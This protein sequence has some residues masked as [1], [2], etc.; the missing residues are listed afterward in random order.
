[1]HRGDYNRLPGRILGRCA[2]GSGV[3]GG[4]VRRNEPAD[5]SEGSLGELPPR[6]GEET[7]ISKR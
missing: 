5:R 3:L 2:G 6:Q 1:M 4:C 7:E